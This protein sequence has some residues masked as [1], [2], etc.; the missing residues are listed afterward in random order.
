MCQLICIEYVCIRA[1]GAATEGA[2]RPNAAQMP[3]GAALHCSAGRTQGSRT[4]GPLY[5]CSTVFVL[6]WA[7]SES[8]IWAI[9]IHINNNIWE[10]VYVRYFLI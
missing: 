3:G 7:V 9:G 6:Y 4:R 10:P 1:W 2:D 5:N 8:M